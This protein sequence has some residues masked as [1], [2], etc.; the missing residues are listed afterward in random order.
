M[1]NKCG[2][3]GRGAGDKQVCV[4]AGTGGSK[5]K[6]QRSQWKNWQKDS[7]G[8][9]SQGLKCTKPHRNKRPQEDVSSDGFLFLGGGQE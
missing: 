9:M 2:N 8:R 7:S 5:W 4:G 1:T 3:G 6:F